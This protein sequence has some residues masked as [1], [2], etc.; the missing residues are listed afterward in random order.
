MWMKMIMESGTS[1]LLLNGVPGKVLHCRRGV[2][3]GDSLSP[4]LFVVAADL[5]HS[6]VN[7]ALHRGVLNLPLP[8]RCGP[9]FS[10]VQ[11]ADGTLLVLEA[12]SRQLLALKVL[13]NTFGESTGLKVNYHKS[14]IY[15]INVSQGRMKILAGT[16]GYQIGT[17]KPKM[18][19]F[20][21]LVQ[22]IERR[23]TATSNFLTQAGRLE[24]VNSVL[25]ALPTFYMV[26]IKILPTVIKQID[27]YR[28]HCMWRGANLNV[29]KPPLTAWKL[30]TRPKKEGGLGILNLETQ[31]DTLLLKKPE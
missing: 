28:K 31:N 1:A 19:S 18:E 11:Y 25:L 24:M 9:E 23:L 3:Q 22:R 27:K 12:C 7:D 2:R 16:F 20:L 21:P 17:T 13:L 14:N 10:I 30:A 26:K 5:L 15:L 8:K 4:L 29:K 6:I